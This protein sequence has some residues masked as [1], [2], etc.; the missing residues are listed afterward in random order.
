MYVLFAIALL[1]VYLNLAWDA[2]GMISPFYYNMVMGAIFT[3]FALLH[4]NT[5]AGR[6]SIVVLAVLTFAITFIMEYMGVK[7]GSVGRLDIERASL[8]R[9]SEVFSCVS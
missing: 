8:A 7:T 3:C 1:S 9:L 2:E 4:G 5:Y 6:K